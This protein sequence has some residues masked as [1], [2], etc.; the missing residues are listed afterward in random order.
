[1]VEQGNE[2]GYAYQV[3]E[4]VRMYICAKFQH[5]SPCRFEVRIQIV[6]EDVQQLDGN[7]AAS[8]GRCGVVI[9][10]MAVQVDGVGCLAPFYRS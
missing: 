9:A 1:M 7:L 3:V 6:G 10:K 4:D 5:C 2:R 8:A